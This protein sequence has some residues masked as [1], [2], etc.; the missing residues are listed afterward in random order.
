MVQRLHRCLPYL[1]ML[2]VAIA[3]YA[4]AASIDGPPASSGRIGPDVWPKAVIGFMGLLCLYEIVRRLLLAPAAPA[5]TGGGAGDQKVADPQDLKVLLG[6]I[7]AIALYVLAVGWLGFFLSTALFLG[8]FAWIGGFRR[9]V[10]V[11]AIAFSGALLTLVLF[12]RVA[13]VSL[14]L[15]EG[16]FRSLSL[17]LLQLIGVR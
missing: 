6:S 7:A 10:W 8:A 11:L 1:V 12:M 16:P 3:L 13:Y 17:I 14:P 15:G 4:A 9:L 2:G 5:P